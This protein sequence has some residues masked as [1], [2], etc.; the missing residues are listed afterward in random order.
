MVC[1]AASDELLGDPGKSY[2]HLKQSINNKIMPSTLAYEEGTGTRGLFET[3]LSVFFGSA[4][5]GF[6]VAHNKT[7]SCLKQKQ[8]LLRSHEVSRGKPGRDRVGLIASRPET[9]D[10]K[11]TKKKRLH[12][13]SC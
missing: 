12:N 4:S 5:L 7:F 1:S 8:N 10:F 11:T 6:L 9:S 13:I 2:V 3:L